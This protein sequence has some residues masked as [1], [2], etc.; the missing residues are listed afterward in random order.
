MLGWKSRRGDSNRTKPH[1]FLSLLVVAER[2][3]KDQTFS[4]YQQILFKIKYLSS[5]IDAEVDESD[6][7]FKKDTNWQIVNR[8]GFL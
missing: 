1:A 4:L 8:C 3:F 6:R 5:K 7:R 2:E